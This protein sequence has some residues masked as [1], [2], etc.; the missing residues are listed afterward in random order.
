VPE[1]IYI[2]VITLAERHKSG[3]DVIPGGVA[4]IERLVTEPMSQTVDT[5]GGLLNEEAG[6]KLADAITP[7]TGG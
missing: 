2:L 5:E 3:N 6:Q 7:G 4:V 1:K